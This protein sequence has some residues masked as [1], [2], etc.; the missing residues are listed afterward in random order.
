MRGNTLHKRLF[1]DTP[2]KERTKGRSAKFIQLRNESLLTTYYYLAKVKKVRYVDI[3][4]KLSK[5]Y[6][7][8]PYTLTELITANGEILKQLNE[9]KP[10]GAELQKKLF[11][12]N[13]NMI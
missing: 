5:I 3:I 10:S 2:V 1:E 11:F 8:S 9:S 7:L 6:F 4:E 12:L 13:L